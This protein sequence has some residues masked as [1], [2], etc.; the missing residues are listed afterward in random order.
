MKMLYPEAS[1]KMKPFNEQ[2]KKE[3]AQ[4]QKVSSHV[5]SQKRSTSKDK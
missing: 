5:K 3:G 1:Q 2:E 4:T